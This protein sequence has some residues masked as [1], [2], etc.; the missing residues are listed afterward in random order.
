MDIESLYWIY[1]SC[2]R[3]VVLKRQ[4]HF[5]ILFFIFVIIS[6]RN[7]FANCWYSETISVPAT[8]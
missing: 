8:A 2:M 1:L 6:L 4:M 5:I 7:Y 3:N